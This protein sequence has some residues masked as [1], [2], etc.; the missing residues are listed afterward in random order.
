[1]DEPYEGDYRCAS[2]FGPDDPCRNMATKTVREPFTPRRFA[3]LLCDECAD[4]AS[5]MGYHFDE[6]ATI[7]LSRD[8]E[9]EQEF[10]SSSINCCR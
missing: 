8:I 10:E 9:R 3:V 4:G 2:N 5:A 7:Q 6:E 1:M